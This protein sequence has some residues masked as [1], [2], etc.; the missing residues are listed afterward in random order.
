MRLPSVMPIFSSRYLFTVRCLLLL[1]AGVDHVG[2]VPRYH[3]CLT[4]LCRTV[5]CWQSADNSAVQARHRAATDFPFSISNT[6]TL[7]VLCRSHTV[8]RRACAR[9]TLYCRFLFPPGHSVYHC[10]SAILLRFLLLFGD[11]L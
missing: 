10:V 8:V 9:C 11:L 4:V 3:L 1:S 5:I 7:P 2:A 6:S